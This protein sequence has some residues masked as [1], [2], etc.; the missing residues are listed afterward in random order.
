MIIMDPYNAQVMSNVA[1]ASIISFPVFGIATLV[2]SEYVD[3]RD[4][5]KRSYSRETD[6]MLNE[7]LRTRPLSDDPRFQVY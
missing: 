1:L 6:R 2:F 5:R 4:D 3:R 7:A